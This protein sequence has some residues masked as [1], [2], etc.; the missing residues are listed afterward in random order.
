MMDYFRLYMVASPIFQGDDIAKQINIAKGAC[1]EHVYI[2]L[3]P[4]LC[5]QY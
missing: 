1:P 5:S 3:S 2:G 4:A